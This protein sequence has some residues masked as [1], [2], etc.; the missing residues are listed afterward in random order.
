MKLLPVNK[1]EYHHILL[2][3][4]GALVVLL[5]CK[6]TNVPP[7][8]ASIVGTIVAIGIFLLFNTE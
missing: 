7:I 1:W 5:V 6:N 4:A 2:G 3:V 8:L